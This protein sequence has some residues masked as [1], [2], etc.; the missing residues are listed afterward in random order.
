[1]FLSFIDFNKLGTGGIIS[2]VFALIF[3]VCLV[4]LFV[5]FLAVIFYGGGENDNIENSSSSSDYDTDNEIV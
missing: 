5:C 3:I 4:V 2:L 1:M